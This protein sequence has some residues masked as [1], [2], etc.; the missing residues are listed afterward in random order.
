VTVTCDDWGA[1]GEIRACCHGSSGCESYTDWKKIPVDDRPAGGNHIADSFWSVYA[2]QAAAWDA[3]D[4]PGNME[5]DGDGFTF[6]DEYRGTMNGTSV[7][8]V[9]HHRH[10]PSHKDLFLYDQD[11]LHLEGHP[12][13]KYTL[14]TSMLVW[15]L[16]GDPPALMNGTGFRAAGHRHVT[17]KAEFTHASP[18]NNQYALHILRQNLGGIGSW[19]YAAGD[20]TDASPIGPP[21]TAVQIRVD[22]AQVRTDVAAAISDQGGDPAGAQSAASA[23]ISAREATVTTTHEMSHGTDVEHHRAAAGGRQSPYGDEYCGDIACVIR[24]DYDLVDV[25]DP[26]HPNMFG[27]RNAADS[28]PGTQPPRFVFSGYTDLDLSDL[29]PVLNTFCTTDNDCRGQIDVKD[30]T[31][32]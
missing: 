22:D 21:A 2:D 9:R 19:G 31:G 16:N 27:V 30:D 14:I 32:P 8:Y 4:F 7:A 6:Y 23:D 20:P 25:A 26:A 11:W 12:N 13:H 29:T 18:L 1:W 28:P 24:Y 17:W 3:D 15:Y 5:R 10:N